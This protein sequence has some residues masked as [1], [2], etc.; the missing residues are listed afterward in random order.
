MA[1]IFHIFMF[2][3]RYRHTVWCIITS[4]LIST[5]VRRAGHKTEKA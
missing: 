2:M 1:M 4:S 5:A 3:D